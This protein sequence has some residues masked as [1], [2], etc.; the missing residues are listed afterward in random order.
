M[1]EE[2]T[3]M[4]VR[5]DIV[6]AL[7]ALQPDYA[8]QAT[9]FA[10]LWQLKIKRKNS[11]VQEAVQ[12]AVALGLG[13]DPETHSVSHEQMIARYTSGVA[14]LPVAMASVPFLLENYVLNDMFNEVFPFGEA[15]PQQHFVKLVT[16]L[17]LVRLMLAAQCNADSLPSA[18]Q[19]ARTIQVFCKKYQHDQNFAH[20]VNTALHNTGWQS[21]EKVYRFLKT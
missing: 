19:M 17:G 4:V 9:V 18:E 13:A 10:S 1:L 5:G 7:S 12:K 11:V 2:I 20:S 16:R 21:L 15:T 3:T 6:E 14:K 8:I